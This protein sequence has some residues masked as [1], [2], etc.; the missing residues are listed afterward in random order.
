M[1]NLFIYGEHSLDRLNSFTSVY[2]ISLANVSK[3]GVSKCMFEIET[4][5]GMV[6]NGVGDEGIDHGVS[7]LISIIY[8]LR[9]LGLC[10][11]PDPA[12][13]LSLESFVRVAIRYELY[14]CSYCIYVHL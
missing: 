6:M 4:V 7:S 8:Q 13:T 10:Q 11:R 14:A 1:L 9:S 3:Y 2:V 5:C 12:A